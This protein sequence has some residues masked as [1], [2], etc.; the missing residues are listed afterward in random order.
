MSEQTI[1]GTE[2]IDRDV[3]PLTDAVAVVLPQSLEASLADAAG[4]SF[5]ISEEQIKETKINPPEIQEELKQLEQAAVAAT[6]AVIADAKSGEMQERPDYAFMGR[7]STNM[8]VHRRANPDSHFV[9]DVVDV[10]GG[11]WYNKKDD[12][13]TSAPAGIDASHDLLMELAEETVAF[14]AVIDADAE[15]KPQ[16]QSDIV[17][18]TKLRDFARAMP[19]ENLVHNVAVLLINGFRSININDRLIQKAMAVNTKEVSGTI[20]IG[21]QIHGQQGVH[22][23]RLV[24][25]IERQ[26]ILSIAKIGGVTVSEVLN[27]QKPKTNKPKAVPEQPQAQ[28]TNNRSDATPGNAQLMRRLIETNEALIVDQRRMQKLIETM[29]AKNAELQRD[30]KNANATIKAVLDSNNEVMRSLATLTKA[31]LER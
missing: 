18:L 12:V 17:N 1:Q 22:K 31:M 15:G 7:D 20:T 30:V 16:D 19:N 9:F 2:N 26:L 29:A 13:V 4:S 3:Q 8:I 23:Y 21:Y 6:A 14:F 11:T 24:G 27:K 5:T 25:D 28:A 10:E